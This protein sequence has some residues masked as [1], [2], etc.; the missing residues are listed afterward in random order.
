MDQMLKP[1]EEN[2]LQ[3]HLEDCLE[4]RTFFNGIKEVENLLLPAMQRQ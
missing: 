1:E 3:S 4:C 2:T